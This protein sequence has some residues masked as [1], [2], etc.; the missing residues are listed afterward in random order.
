[1]QSGKYRSPGNR[2]TQTSPSDCQTEKHD[3]S[4]QRTRL[5]CSIESS[6]GVLSGCCTQLLPLCYNTNHS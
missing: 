6:G 4:L 3:L 2:Q 5:H 1:M